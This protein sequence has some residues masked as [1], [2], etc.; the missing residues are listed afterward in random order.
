VL[1][2]S[3]RCKTSNVRRFW[4]A[5]GPLFKASRTG[6]LTSYYKCYNGKNQ[7]QLSYMPNTILTTTKH[8]FNNVV[9]GLNL[10]PFAHHPARKQLIRF[11]QSECRDEDSL[12]NELMAEID[13]LAKTPASECET[14]LLIVPHVLMD[15]YDYQFFIE[16]ANRYLKREQWLGIFQLASFHPDYCFTGSEPQEASNLTNRSPYPIIH[17]LR[18]QSLSHVLEQ[19]SH[20]EE[21]PQTNINTMETLCDNEKRKLF[22]YLKDD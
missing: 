5:S 10:C 2:L 6:R 16:E 18:E 9:L 17:I 7:Q 12:L 13:Y 3:A 21:I 4:A 20:P 11:H 19:V 1:I 14:T 15:F 8:W 22:F